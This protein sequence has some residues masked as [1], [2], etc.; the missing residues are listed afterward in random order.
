MQVNVDSGF[1]TLSMIMIGYLSIYFYFIYVIRI[2]RHERE[3][4]FFRALKEGLKQKTITTIDDVVNI[5]KGVIGLSSDDLS[6]RYTLSKLLR[7]FMV[8][9]V[10]KD[11]RIIDKSIKDDTRRD[12]KEK[13]SEFIRQNEITSP[14]A[15]LPPA[16][17]NVLSDISLFIE[18]KDFESIKRKILELSGLI[19][20]RNDDMEKIESINRWA[21][22]LGV[23]GL[24]LTIIFGILALVK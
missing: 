9:L 7:R 15:D 22:P 24:I 17:R 2:R 19:Q 1:I 20:A 8:L 13:L 21:V 5:Y 4:K 3:E 14:Y 12:W 23:V 18:R 6:Y 11:N 16:E 10:S